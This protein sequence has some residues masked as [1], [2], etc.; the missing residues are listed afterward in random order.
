MSDSSVSGNVKKPAKPPLLRR[1]FA[2]FLVLLFAVIGG[3]IVLY[4]KRTGYD[5]LLTSSAPPTAQMDVK[6]AAKPA[7][8]QALPNPS[9]SEMVVVDD[10]IT[11]QQDNTDGV[12]SETEPNMVI[13]ENPSDV[14]NLKLQL[15]NME[16]DF[17][18]KTGNMK[19]ATEMAGTISTLQKEVLSLTEKVNQLEQLTV[20]LQESSRRGVQN[21]LSML[22]AVNNLQMAIASGRPFTQSMGM[23]KKLAEGNADMEKIIQSLQGVAESGIADLP[24]LQNE[25]SKIARQLMQAQAEQNAVD[26]AADWAGEG[27]IANT[28]G[29]VAS[30]I[31]VRR[32]GDEANSDLEANINSI[33]TDLRQNRL[34]QALDT[35]KSLPSHVRTEDL[36]HWQ[37]ELAEKNTAETALAELQKMILTRLQ[38]ST[39]VN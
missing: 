38:S 22:L 34:A 23:L 33:E 15:K 16:I 14:E 9:S 36:D 20:Q 27:V 4:A 17:A 6:Q 5:G 29:K 26:W 2:M 30:L 37:S 11:R 31:T 1:L 32:T 28:I 7:T 10:S 35:A 24:S 12:S 3:S 8:P 39:A 25:F 18:Q 13:S 21:D 19:S